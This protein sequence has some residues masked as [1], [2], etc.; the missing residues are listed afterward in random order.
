MYFVVSV[1]DCIV[2]YLTRCGLIWYGS[3]LILEGGGF[4]ARRV[5]HL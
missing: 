2:L 3:Q 1:S 5:H 4:K